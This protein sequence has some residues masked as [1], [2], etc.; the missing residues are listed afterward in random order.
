MKDLAGARE[1]ISWANGA[2]S[3]DR[4]PPLLAWR[5]EEARWSEKISDAR[6]DL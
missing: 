2:Q 5:D 6:P 3:P 4:L 1:E